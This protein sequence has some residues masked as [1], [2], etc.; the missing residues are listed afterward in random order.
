MTRRVPISQILTTD[1]TTVDRDQPLSEVYKALRSSP[2]HHM[3]VMDGERVVGM[4][5]SSDILRL[6]YDIDGFDDKAMSAMLDYQF[7]IED[8]MTTELRHLNPEAT[9]HQ[10]AELL[11]DGQAHSV[12]VMDDG[13]KLHGIVTTTD[14]VR[15]LRDL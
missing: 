1:V 4:I 10:A 9:I 14:L 15:Y 2:F 6:A 8:A 11:S 12:L 7:N 5:S 13:G 3:P